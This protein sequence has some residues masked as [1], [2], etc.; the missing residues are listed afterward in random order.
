MTHP[1]PPRLVWHDGL[2]LGFAPMDCVHE[3]FVDLVDSLLLARDD[4]LGAALEAVAAHA[5]A[6][7]DAEDTW[8]VETGFPGRE[9]HAEEHAAVLASIHGVQ[10]RVA[11]GDHEAARRLARA[12]ADWFP[13]HADH[14]DS[15]LAH[16]MCKQRFGGKPVVIRRHIESFIPAAGL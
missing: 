10:R 9:C 1:A 11:I 12:L 16:W 3:E 4:Q 2:A 13:G 8:M 5:K 6:H 15:A 14:L 7:F